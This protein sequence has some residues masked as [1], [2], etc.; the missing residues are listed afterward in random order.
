MSANYMQ[1]W[2]EAAKQRVSVRSYTGGVDKDTFYEL[3]KMAVNLRT[4]EA[5]IELRAKAGVLGKTFPV[6]LIGGVSGTNCFAAVIVRNDCDYMGGYIGEAFML[7]CV[8]MGLGTCWLGGTYNH[9][10][11]KQFIELENDERIVSIISF[12]KVDVLP[13]APTKK[14]LEQLTGLSYEAIDKLSAWQQEAIRTA[15]NAPS[16]RNRQ[17]WEIGVHDDSLGIV[18][19]SNNWGFGEVDCGIAMLHIE[20]GA[21]KYGVYGEWQMDEIEKYFIPY[22]ADEELD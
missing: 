9:K 18:C 19:N 6:S 1:R 12:G 8:A 13:K 5:R 11:L 3:K 14:S 22:E 15:K 4:D 17:P 21:A 16:A 10:A 20:L 2:Y 7:E